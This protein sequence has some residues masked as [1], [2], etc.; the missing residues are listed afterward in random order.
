MD[1]SALLTLQSAQ[2]EASAVGQ[3]RLSALA[4][5]AKGDQNAKL[6]ADFEAMCLSAL[7]KPMFEG[8]TTDGPFGGG[9]GEA[10]MRSFQIDAMAQGITRQGGIGISDMM[11]KQLLKLQEGGL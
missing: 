6:G 9:Q 11:Q 10:A 1:S 2:S 4:R 5:S 7:L 3:T 8:L